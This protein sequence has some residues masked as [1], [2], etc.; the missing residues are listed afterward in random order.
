MP[1]RSSENS[2][3]TTKAPLRVC[4]LADVHLGY[5]RYAK[6]TKGGQNQ[7][8]VDVNHA[9]Q[10]AIGRIISVKPDVTVIAGDLFH[11]VRP[12]NHVVTFCFRQLRKLAK[13]T[14]APIIIVGGNH[15]APKR[16]D[17]GSV[18]QL[19]GEIDG[20]Y[21]ADTGIETFG[22]K[23]IGCAVT[24]VPHL[25]LLNDA[26]HSADP[27][28]GIDKNASLQ[29]GRFSLRADD[30]FTHNVLVVHAQVNEGWVSD[31]GGVEL[32]LRAL[33]PHEWDYIAL[34]HVHIHRTVGLNAAY[35]GSIEHTATNIWSEGKEPKGF[36][37]VQLPSGKRI[38]HP[39]TTPR[40]VVVLE[41]VDASD[42]PPEAVMSAI[43]ERAE[44]TP[45]GLDGK[46]VRLD[47][48]NISRETYRHLNHKELRTLRSKALN[49][50]IDIT[51]AAHTASAH[52]VER[53]GKGR[54]R[55]E[56]ESFCSTWQIPGVSQQELSRVLLEY[57]AKVE[58]KYEAS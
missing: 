24:C 36:L 9:F 13:E 47:I 30:R 41:P 56:L 33:S 58:A 29:A 22:F 32:D 48:R 28:S 26:P 10:E 35:S 49:L 19:F 51:F 11:S 12:S 23:E 1:L 54:L 45:G 53:P 27:R 25:A 7:R 14:G 21:V 18:L 42:L 44:G 8:E 31:F 46:I 50:S 52:T 16:T 3:A 5:R 43:V 15:E 17:T 2:D 6:L 37:E 4:H 34:G 57:V 20:V 40:D 39:L 55:D 38:F